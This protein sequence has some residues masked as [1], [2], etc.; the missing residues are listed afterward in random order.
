MVH[1]V[2]TKPLQLLHIDLCGPSAVESLN[3]KKYI[4]VIVDDFTKFTWVFFLHLKS[5]TTSTFI[6]FIT[7]AKVRLWNVVRKI[8]SDNG[9]EFVNSLLD[10]FL[11][12]KGIDDNLSAPYIPQQNG[13]VERRNRTLVEAGRAML[14]FANLSLYFWAEAVQTV[15]FVK[16]RSIINK[17]TA[18]TPYEGLK[19]K[20]A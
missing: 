3:K 16:N 10:D 9:T 20:E 18:K 11:I 8:R 2:V 19:K 13:V 14:N 12:S 1:A 7:N 17:R 6:N 4:L 15:C 5:E